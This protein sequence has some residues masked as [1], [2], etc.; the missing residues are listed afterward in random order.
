[1]MAAIEHGQ[2]GEI[3]ALINSG[4]NLELREDTRAS[5][6]FT[7]QAAFL[8]QDDAL[9][10]LLAAG[11]NVESQNGDG[12]TPLMC[13]VLANHP[14]TVTLLI[15]RGANVNAQG[16]RGETPLSLVKGGVESEVAKQLLAA[17]AQK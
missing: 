16:F 6:T 9:V 5:P 15:R 17:G 2:V 12:Y 11:A 8:G 7:T 13:A 3:K 1:M 10:A 14:S 4:I